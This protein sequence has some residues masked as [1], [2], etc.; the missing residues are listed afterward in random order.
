MGI[1]IHKYNFQLQFV[2]GTRLTPSYVYYS[3]DETYI[4]KRAMNRFTVD[5]ENVFFDSKR[6]LAQKM[7]SKS[8]KKFQKNWPFK[9]A[10]HPDKKDN[11][12]HF[13][14]AR[15]GVESLISPEKV[16]SDIL[17]FLIENA[18]EY[19]AAEN[20]DIQAVIT[21]PAYFNMHQKTATKEAA[22]AAGIQVK[23]ILSEPVAAALAYQLE[24]RGDKKLQKG[25]SVFIFDLGGGTFDVTIMRIE[26]DGTYKVIALG[27][28][29][30]L[31]G[32]DFDQVIADIIEERLRKQLG[33]DKV[34][35]LMS[36]PKYRCRLID[37]AHDI[38]ES[39]TQVTSEDLPLDEI[40]PGV[41]NEELKRSEFEER[42]RHLQDKIK[43]CCESTLRDSGI[44]SKDINHVLL[45]GG[46]SR[47]NLVENILRTIFSHKKLFLRTVSGDESIA[48]GATIYAAKLLGVAESEFIQNLKVRDALPLSIGIEI[49]S[50]KFIPILEK[51]S[52]IPSSNK[53][54]LETDKDNQRTKIISV[55]L[56]S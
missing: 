48:I 11:K 54:T 38:R 6:L 56:V 20:E 12:A 42:A 27:G 55:R 8:V 39:F 35:E 34:N 3:S 37:F 31:G 5:P 13:V 16:S 53:I 49:S 30:H 29:T 1:F 47:M 23:Q 40:C 7:D 43:E 9:V 4:G 19:L 50:N 2:T 14:N 18:R 28:D 10:V 15:N 21:V 26:E 41:E 36:K 22:E 25:E 52:Q 17:K 46:A 45:V 44:N 51:N 33:D 24:L 32:R